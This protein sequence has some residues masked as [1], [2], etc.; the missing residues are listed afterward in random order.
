MRIGILPWGHSLQCSIFS[1]LHVSTEEG[2][3][4]DGAV[5]QWL[6]D[7]MNISWVLVELINH[8]ALWMGRPL[9]LPWTVAAQLWS[10]ATSL[11]GMVC[12]CSVLLWAMISKYSRYRGGKSSCASCNQPGENELQGD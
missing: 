7:W 6:E 10:S 8:E 2:T 9:F 5:E 12:L 11:P 3:V 1:D 4:T